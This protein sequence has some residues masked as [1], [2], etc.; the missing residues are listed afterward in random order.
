MIDGAV[1]GLEELFRR[2]EQ[3]S[4]TARAKACEQVANLYCDGLL[5]QDYRQRA[6]DAFRSLCADSEALIRR[7]LAECLKSVAS[8]PTDI[9]LS[10][11]NDRPDIAAP[12]LL[13]SP[14]L[15]DEDLVTIIRDRSGSHRAAIAKRAN[16]SP[17]V[18]EA[19]GDHSLKDASDP[20]LRRAV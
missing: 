11:A 1:I 6:E 7:L 20:A 10:L 13:A 17:R 9:A 2:L 14:V 8:L 3:P 18:V 12:F 4:W 15:S 5:E 19:M 16:L